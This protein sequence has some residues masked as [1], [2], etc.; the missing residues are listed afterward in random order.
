MAE[1]AHA[2]N[3]GFESLRRLIESG[4]IETIEE[5]IAAL[6]LDLRTHYTLVFSS[7][8]LQEASFANPRAILFGTSAQFIVTFN[9]DASARGYGAVETMEFDARGNRFLFR[10]I[11]FRPDEASPGAALISEPNPARCAACHGRPARPI[12]DASPSWPGV[13]GERYHAGLSSAEL[14][15]MRE[16]LSA[17]S[18]HPRYHHL[19]GASAF[20]DRETYVQSSRGLYNG[21]SIEPPNA[22]L[23]ALLA[24][25]N[26]R[27]IDSEL[28]GHPAFNAHSYVLLAAA[29]SN[30]G[31][32]ADFYPAA[33]RSDIDA[34]F[35]KFSGATTL[36][37]RRQLQTK[38]LRLAG[39]E[40]P[41]R[42]LALT[43]ELTKLRFV[44]ER[45]LGIPTRHWA[46]AFERGTYDFSAPDGTLTMEQALFERVVRGDVA[47][48]D[49]V[50]YR[51]FNSEDA[52]CEHLRRESRQALAK[53]YGAGMNSPPGAETAAAPSVGDG[54][55]SDAPLIER[56]AACHSS[57]VAPPLP[58]A[59]P[60]ALGARLLGGHYPRGR[61]L[62]EILYRLTPQAGANRMPSGIN[63]TAAEQ[64]GLEDYFLSL[65]R[66]AEA[67]RADPKER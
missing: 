1:S 41:N 30:C 57:D 10:E 53:W 23:S 7:R 17:Q 34:D 36:A 2:E 58:F 15:G 33:M 61:L 66:S 12:W 49:L 43:T 52:Y 22:Q 3:F 4:R 9:G 55:R 46:L 35:K 40:N 19:L 14:K 6:P 59:D 25:L 63:V 28:A 42:G 8:S 39:R 56:C 16:F 11:A 21:V 44:S 64:R 31:A 20:A 54:H 26:V 38:T 45:S 13:Y 65:A 32:V 50:S 48:R 47:L 37:D 67:S 27:S 18:N 29:G 24:T 51:T 62:D 5:L 60:D